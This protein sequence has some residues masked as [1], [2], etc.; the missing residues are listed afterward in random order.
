[1]TDEKETNRISLVIALG[2]LAWLILA[3]SGFGVVS[4]LFYGIVRMFFRYAFDVE[5]PNPFH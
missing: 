5:L 1:M 4:L 3:L 2:L